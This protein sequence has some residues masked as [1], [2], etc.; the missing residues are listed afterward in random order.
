M[1]QVLTFAYVGEQHTKN[2]SYA[3][4]LGME[5]YPTDNS[6]IVLNQKYDEAYSSY[7]EWTMT[8]AFEPGG[9]GICWLVNCH[10]RKASSY[11]YSVS[12][13]VALLLSVCLSL[14]K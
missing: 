3:Q 14:V 12:V 4:H 8:T 2:V 7:G 13:S 9:T 6:C 11:W 1:S 5:Y 10:S